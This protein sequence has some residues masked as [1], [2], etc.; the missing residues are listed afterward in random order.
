MQ[1]EAPS[2]SPGSK[3][4]PPVLPPSGTHLV[5]LF[6]VPLLIVGGLLL[7][8]FLFLKLTGGSV[9]RSPESFLADL[10]SGNPDVRWRA[11]Q[12]LAQVLTRDERLASDPAF[13]L[14]LTD[15][16]RQAL[17]DTEETEKAVA[18]ELTKD[19]EANVAE[20][21]KD[22]EAGRNYILYLS[23]CVGNL[24]NPVGTPLLKR[25]AVD[26]GSG[27]SKV[28]ATRRWRALWSLANL[29]E[30]LKR[31]DGLPPERQ[32]AVVAEFE[33][34]AT[35][36]GERS[37][38]AGETAAYLKGRREGA[39]PSLGVDE[40][41]VRCTADKNPF[42]REVAVFALNFWDG[43][44]AVDEALVARLDDQGQG[45]ELLAEFYDGD[46]NRDTQFTKTPGLRIRYNAAVA[47]ARRGSCRA[48]I[49]LLKDM[50]DESAQLDQNRIRFK[51]DGRE[52]ADE[53]TAYDV[54][55]T[56]LR[57]VAELHRKSPSVNLTA[58]EPAIDKLKDGSANPAVRKEAERTREALGK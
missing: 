17:H 52:A 19:P 56:A 49:D 14:E 16:L 37:R 4:L 8:A 11:A 39:A 18:E 45:E 3:G 40:V 43:G 41:L 9:V 30:N 27:P 29:G 57:A 54:M 5:K 47:L 7:G 38:L 55:Q 25:M 6:I 13:G 28:Q 48:P 34:Q 2:P 32:E 12:D 50:L 53:G 44:S 23:G 15:E 24:S 46:K 1:S 20:K 33:R 36:E 35:G 10:R 58:L 51:K 22:L 26:G 21:Q 42:L 31:F